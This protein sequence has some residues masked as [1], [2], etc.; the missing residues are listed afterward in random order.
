MTIDELSTT[1]VISR[2]IELRASC[3]DTFWLR[4]GAGAAIPTN[5]EP[6]AAILAC[7]R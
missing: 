2:H 6:P 3:S 1:V 7:S 5:Q 4:L